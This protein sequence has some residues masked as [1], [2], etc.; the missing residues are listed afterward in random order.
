MGSISSSD[1]A[2]SVGV[3][4]GVKTGACGSA[5]DF[6]S[7]N[8][9]PAGDGVVGVGV[10]GMS[11]CGTK[12]DAGISSDLPKVLSSSAFAESNFSDGPP[13]VPP[14]RSRVEHSACFS[15]ILRAA[16]AIFN[17]TGSCGGTRGCGLG[18]SSSVKSGSCGS[19]FPKQCGVSDGVTGACNKFWRTGG[20]ILVNVAWI[21]D[22]HEALILLQISSVE[23]A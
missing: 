2:S 16:C 7:K 18:F 19:G 21:V 8:G 13:K 20:S 6:S 14:G 12:G 10:T 15:L 1:G 22:A 9:S 4:V 3:T 23:P 17:R 11:G 5:G